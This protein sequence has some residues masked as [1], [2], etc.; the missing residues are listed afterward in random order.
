MKSSKKTSNTQGK[1][2]EAGR[3]L[4][5]MLET[6]GPYLPKRDFGVLPK[7]SEWQISSENAPSAPAHQSKR[8]VDS[9]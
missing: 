9:E 6:I 7:P 2:K 5:K 8:G 3:T 4:D 1:I